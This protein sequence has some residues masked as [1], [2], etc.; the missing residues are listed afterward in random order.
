M[1]GLIAEVEIYWL[2]PSHQEN[3]DWFPNYLFYM[4]K[5]HEIGAYTML[6]DGE[7]GE[8]LMEIVQKLDA[9]EKRN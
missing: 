4:A 6:N 8:K 5:V 7:N 1:A 9:M 2:S 3:L